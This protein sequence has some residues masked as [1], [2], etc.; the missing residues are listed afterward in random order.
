[1]GKDV[2]GGTWGHDLFGN[3]TVVTFQN[4]TMAAKDRLQKAG[5]NGSNEVAK[6]L[7]PYSKRERVEAQ[8]RVTEA[9]KQAGHLE[10]ILKA[11]PTG[12]AAGLDW[13]G[14]RET[15]HRGIT[16]PATFLDHTAGCNWY[17]LVEQKRS[18][19]S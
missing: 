6:W 1:M 12:V 4:I 10:H 8:T 18:N 2:R 13:E 9:G 19:C 17:H 3:D 11:E 7:S 16:M 14:R 5:T 15:G